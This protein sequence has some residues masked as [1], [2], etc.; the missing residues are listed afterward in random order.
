MR[1]SHSLRG[2]LGSVLVLACAGAYG[3]GGDDAPPILS[4]SAGRGGG[5][6]DAGDPFVE[7]KDGGTKPEKDGGP[8][9]P[10]ADAKAPVV[11][12]LSPEPADDPN[13]GTVITSELLEARCRVTKSTAAGA[14]EV[15]FAKVRISMID[16]DDPM[17]PVVGVV[18]AEGNGEF[19]AEFKLSD[20]NNGKWQFKCEAEDLGTPVLT[21]SDTIETYVDLG[22]SVEI[23]SPADGSAHRLL[24]NV[25][26]SF[27][28]TD[29]PVSK[30]DDESTPTGITLVVSGVPFDFT[31][32]ASDPGLYDAAINFDDRTL[33]PMPPTTA[34]IVVSAKSSRTPEAPTRTAKIDISIDS[35]GPEITV[36]APPAGSI[37]HHE[38]DLQLS[39]TDPSGVDL[40]TVIGSIFL[41][42]EVFLLDDWDVAGNTYSERFD[43]RSFDETVP[44]LTINIVAKDRVGNESERSHVVYIDN[45]PPRISLDSPPIREFTENAGVVTCSNIFDPLGSDAMSDLGT[46]TSHSLYRARIQERTNSAP[47]QTVSFISGVNDKTVRLFAQPDPSIPLLIDTDD[48]PDNLCD[49]INYDDLR[50]AQRPTFVELSPVIDSGSAYYAMMPDFADQTVPSAGCT[51]GTATMPPDK[52]CPVTTMTRVIAQQ[53]DSPDPPTAIYALMPSNAPTGACTGLTWGLLDLVGEGWACLAARVEDKIKNVGVSRPIRVCFD[54][55]NG[56]PVCVSPNGAPGC[57]DG[58]KLPDDF[59]PVAL[60]AR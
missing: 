16:T 28:V 5:K 25:P 41:P 4:S 15:N 17:H 18:V 9:K 40:D 58:C 52:R 31:E 12:V 54:D 37:V 35:T 51:M 14:S 33:F 7:P 47:G 55:G 42:D 22:P 6:K 46:A 56:T 10:P 39:V 32:S 21:G 11:K 50:M 45:I 2:L 59:Q 13:D 38:V 19:S 29:A 20:L 60:R 26:V 48:D 3:C 43:T 1:T 57:T 49:E 8:S 27:R 44:Q 36:L 23:V 24:G 34:E 53:I 30:D